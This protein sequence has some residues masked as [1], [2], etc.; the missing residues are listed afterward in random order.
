M[1]SEHDCVEEATFDFS[2]PDYPDEISV[3]F[4]GECGVC[5][6]SLE[7]IFSYVG[8]YDPEEKEFLTD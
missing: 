4:Y 2:E 8:I 1:S 3:V 7:H 5:G 6:K